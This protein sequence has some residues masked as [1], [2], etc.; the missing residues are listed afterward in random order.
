MILR[1]VLKDGLELGSGPKSPAPG[2]R[3]RGR[4]IN[5]KRT[6]P[7]GLRTDLRLARSVSPI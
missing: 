6:C 7:S 2:G 5:K 3:E 4:E 1:Q